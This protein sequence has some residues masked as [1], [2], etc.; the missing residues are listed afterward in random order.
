M[1]AACDP[2]TLPATDPTTMPIE[3]PSSPVPEKSK[4]PK[5]ANGLLTAI[6]VEH[7]DKFD[8]VIFEFG[9]EKP[10]AYDLKFTDEVREDPSYR[11]M[12]LNGKAFL[13]LVFHGGT[14]DTSPRES[15]PSKVQR[16]SGPKRMTPDFPIL[17]DVAVAGDFEA[18]L[19]FGIG[20]SR[21]AQVREQTLTNPAR[22]VIEVS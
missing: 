6:R 10:P 14:L 19:S 2:V 4:P 9:G 7:Q 5:A 22:L 1:V 18:T 3:T 15:D 21:R 20:L 16:Y 11:L 8:R 12:T 17:K 13:W